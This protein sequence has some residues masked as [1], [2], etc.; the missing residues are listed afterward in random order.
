MTEIGFYHLLRTSLE[1]ALPRLLIKTLDRGK[2][3]VVKA[4]SPN[5]IKQLDDALWNW[6]PGP[7]DSSFLPHGTENDG[8]SDRQPIWLTHGDDNPNK[9]DFLFLT[10]GADC[11]AISDYARCFNLFDGRDDEAVAHARN[12][13]KD[14]INAGHHLIYWQQG[15]RGW[16]KKA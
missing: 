6:S 10:D 13:W 8:H 9:A 3:A 16:E 12:Q 2:R 4:S 1:E 5:R 7:R 14:W 15:D 11:G